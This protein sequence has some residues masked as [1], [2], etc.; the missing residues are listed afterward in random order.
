MKILGAF[1]AVNLD[2]YKGIVKLKPSELKMSS[3]VTV[4]N[5]VPPKPDLK[6]VGALT[7]RNVVL[8]ARGTN[9]TFMVAVGSPKEG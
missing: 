8:F 3:V 4:R 6:T 2:I 7:L 9:K 1:I 5:R